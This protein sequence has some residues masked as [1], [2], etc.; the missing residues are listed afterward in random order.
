MAVSLFARHRFSRSHNPG[1]LIAAVLFLLVALPLAAQANE[2]KPT[3]SALKKISPLAVKKVASVKRPTGKLKKV[4]KLPKAPP[5]KATGQR[6]G[7][8]RWEGEEIFYSVEISGADAAR[9]AV[10]VGKR[11]TSKG[12]SYV[13]VS[14]KA[15]SHGFFAKTYPVNNKADTFIDP[16]TFQPLRSDK[17]IQEN[18]GKRTYKVKYDPKKYS[19]SVGKEV[20]AKGKKKVNQRKYTRA[21]PNTIH[22]ALSWVFDLRAQPLKKGDVYTYFVYDGWKLS[23]LKVSVVGKEKTWTPLQEYDALKIDVEREILKSTWTGTPGDRGAP[24]LTTREKPY[25]FSTIYLSDDEAR[26]PV[27]IFVTSKKADSE[28]RIVEYKAPSKS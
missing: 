9:A 6:T 23:R 18:G 11:Q 28:L 27:K 10:R 14:A 16:N 8:F 17:V 2:G 3:K 1:F 13:P 15:I 20:K 5:F 25:Y 19:A 4:K 7:G 22:D 12:V 26:V 24:K 21:V